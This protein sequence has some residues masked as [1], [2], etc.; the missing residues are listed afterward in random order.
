MEK[1]Y[2]EDDNKLVIK[3]IK[4]NYL[5]GEP[6]WIEH[7]FTG[8]RNKKIDFRPLID[9]NYDLEFNIINTRGDTLK[10]LG[11]VIYVIPSKYSGDSI[12]GCDNLLSYYG[13][14]ENFPDSRFL[15][16]FYLPA[17]SYSVQALLNIQIESTPHIVLSNKINFTISRPSGE[18]SISYSKWLEIQN[19]SKFDKV[20]TNLENKINDFTEIYPNSVYLDMVRHMLLSYSF[21][22]VNQSEYIKKI[23]MKEIERN[24]NNYYNYYYLSSLQ[25]V[26]N[27]KI[28]F[29]TMLNKYKNIYKNT[30]LER[31]IENQFAKIY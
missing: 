27:N 17:D 8:N 30:L 11:G 2:S 24:P 13:V 5:E 29:S 23:S 12:W 31:F 22:E 7:L 25:G 28:T 6:V 14:P 10:Y 26:L 21:I 1:L 16:R 18:D 20:F 4:S 15:G 3:S 9:P 19:S